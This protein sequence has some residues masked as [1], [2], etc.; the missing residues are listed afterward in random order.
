MAQVESD[1]GEVVGIPEYLV[2]SDVMATAPQGGGGSFASMMYPPAQSAPQSAPTIETAIN[3]NSVNALRTPQLASPMLRGPSQQAAVGYLPGIGSVT[4]GPAPTPAQQPQR[5]GNLPLGY[6]TVDGGAVIAPDG[7]VVEQHRG[8]TVQARR[9]AGATGAD[10]PAGQSDGGLIVVPG[11][12]QRGGGGPPSGA[13]SAD[14]QAY[15]DTFGADRDNATRAQSQRDR[16]AGQRDVVQREGRTDAGIAQFEAE[17]ANRVAQKQIDGA[18]AQ[19][20]QDRQTLADSK[21]DPDRVWKEKGTGARI[22]AALAQGL[23][24]FG[25]SLSGGA[26]YAT[27]IVDQMIRDD[28][29]A[30][31]SDRENKRGDVDEQRQG[32]AG[33]MSRYDDQRQQQAA[34]TALSYQHVQ[35][36]LEGLTA[37]V[38]DVETRERAGAMMQ[39]LERN[40]LQAVQTFQA[41]NADAA[42]RAGAARA[43][44][45]RPQV[46]ME[47]DGVPVPVDPNN[48]RSVTSAI[49]ARRESRASQGTGGLD[50]SQLAT[51]TR[52][53]G[54]EVRDLERSAQELRALQQRADGTEDLPGVGLGHSMLQ[55]AGLGGLSRLAA[56]EDG[57]QVQRDTR[58]AVERSIQAIT[59]ATASDE[60]RAAV[61]ESLGLGAGAT[62]SDY[63]TALRALTSRVDAQREAIDA[64]YPPGVVDSYNNRR[65]QTPGS[66][67]EE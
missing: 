66:F 5:R 14:Q 26:N 57:R 25:A 44:A 37:N 59:G 46:F 6:D 18:N 35:Q 13:L 16:L 27:Q 15:V 47:I 52:T 55:D 4:S 24:A 11:Q 34:Q 50:P 19:L 40:R 9:A 1:N 8:A 39:D 64:S 41:A 49:T 38:Q 36:Q 2:P 17:E 32:I 65:P 51:S 21:I 62:E 58:M 12:R 28:I 31:E 43:R 22:V 54:G 48:Q 45:S 20:D 3:Q 29:A 33:M 63:R 53:Y 42:R 61:R 23:G 67:R 7:T 56:G 60:Q 30:Q 10:G